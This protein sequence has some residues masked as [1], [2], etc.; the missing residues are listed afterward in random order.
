MEFTIP[1]PLGAHA[2]LLA[3]TPV[4]KPPDLSKVETAPDAG[5]ARAD[6]H[7]SKDHGQ[8]P[9]KTE[10][11]TGLSDR[12][13]ID[14]NQPVGPPPSFQVNVLEMEHR[15]QQKLA[16]LEAVRAQDAP[17]NFATSRPVETT[18]TSTNDLGASDA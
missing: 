15:L 1:A 4:R 3:Q 13:D 11:R 18:D 9:Q 7:N 17:Q 12:L 8:T 6:M 5:K 16:R 10:P 2:N 14:T